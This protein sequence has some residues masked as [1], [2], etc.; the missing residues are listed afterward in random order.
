MASTAAAT[1][2]PF[3]AKSPLWYISFH[4]S[5]VTSTEFDIKHN[6]MHD[7]S[8]VCPFASGPICLVL[9]GHK[10]QQSL[11]TFE[12]LRDIVQVHL[13]NGS[14]IVLKTAGKRD[15]LSRIANW[16]EFKPL[17]QN[18]LFFF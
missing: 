18:P 12:T 6:V 14:R 3:V 2:L 16:K 10:R 9:E 8:L 4:A 5:D 7:A 11:K 17:D 1:T 13:Q 15:K